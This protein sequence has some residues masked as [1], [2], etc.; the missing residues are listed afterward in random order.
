MKL[1]AKQTPYSSIVGGGLVL[2]DEAGRAAFMV[3]VRGTT[4][5]I[6]KE[7]DAAI[8]AFLARAINEGGLEVPDV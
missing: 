7:Q 5:G 1:T 6:S 2:T 8:S 4:S 3:M